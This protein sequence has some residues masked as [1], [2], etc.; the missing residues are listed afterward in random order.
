MEGNWEENKDDNIWK[1]DSIEE[2]L[3]KWNS[4]ENLKEL[5]SLPLIVC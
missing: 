4:N 1:G 3:K 5:I 2:F